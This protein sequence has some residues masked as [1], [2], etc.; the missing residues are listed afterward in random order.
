MSPR[1]FLLSDV[2]AEYVTSHSEPLDEVA[3]GLVERTAALGDISGMQV[4]ADQSVL[5]GLLARITGARRAVEVGTFTG[6]SSLAIARGLA[7]D[8][9]LICCDIS[10]EWTALAR[11]AWASAGVDER[12]ELRIG[13]GSE[14]LAGD[15]FGD[16]EPLDMAFVDADKP[17]YIGYHEAL[18]P[19]LRPGGVLAVDNTLWG[20]GV[21]DPEATDANTAAIR[22]YNDHALADERVDTVVM[23]V[24]DGLTLNVKR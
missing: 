13:P 17:G 21:V 18:V 14:T 11:S 8:G 7:H 6:M 22:A 2:L 9:R 5:L 3:A 20:G 4:S 10:E 19:R 23:T 16:G 1:S 24:G 12:I 15:L